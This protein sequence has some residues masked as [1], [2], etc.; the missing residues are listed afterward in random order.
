LGSK[1]RPR[2]E[3]DTMSDELPLHEKL[4]RVESLIHQ[5]EELEDEDVRAQVQE[6]VQH[7]LDYHGAGLAK[8]VEHAARLG[9]TGRELLAAWSRDDLISSLLLLYGLHPADLETRVLG[10][11]EKVRPLLASHGGNVQ[12]VEVDEGVVR[13]RLQ[14]SC[15]GCPSSL[16]T[17]RSTIEE[18]LYAAA[19][20]VTEIQ[21]EGVTPPP[22]VPHD[23][24]VPLQQLAVIT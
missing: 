15:H 14:G 9:D 22:P 2:Q 8:M 12:L 3:T 21:V 13:L 16:V 6:L 18:A 24:F 20:D 10:A 19:P 17:L 1:H 23:G 11:L 7:L 5:A 4:A